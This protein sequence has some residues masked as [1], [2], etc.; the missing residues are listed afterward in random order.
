MA[1]S[2]SDKFFHDWKVI[3]AGLAVY[4]VLNLPLMVWYVF[5]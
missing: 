2:S 5:P 1:R 4:V 3:V